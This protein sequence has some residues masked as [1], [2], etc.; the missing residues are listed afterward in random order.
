M[1]VQLSLLLGPPELEPV[2]W[3]P[4]RRL[5]VLRAV[6]SCETPSRSVATPDGR[7]VSKTVAAAGRDAD[8]H[9]AKVAG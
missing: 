6:Q 9:R 1:S 4:M 7:R 8:A 2:P 3:P 5:P